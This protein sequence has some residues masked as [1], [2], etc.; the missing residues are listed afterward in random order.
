MNKLGLYSLLIAA[1]ISTASVHAETTPPPAGDWVWIIN[2]G[3]VLKVIVLKDGTCV[4]AD[5]LDK[6]TWRLIQDAGLVEFKWGN[7]AI[8][9]LSAKNSKSVLEG[10]NSGGDKIIAV[11]IP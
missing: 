8:D 3:L 7:G 6:G 2:D 9:K 11:K 1:V 5:A 4:R 10:T